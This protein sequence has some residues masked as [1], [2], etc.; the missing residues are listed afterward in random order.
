MLQGFG[1]VDLGGGL[2]PAFLT[3]AFDATYAESANAPCWA[4][5]ATAFRGNCSD[6]GTPNAF[7]NARGDTNLFLSR[8]GIQ[9]QC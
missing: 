8:V 7:R 5:S 2:T 4:A 3:E 9:F 1:V 6:F